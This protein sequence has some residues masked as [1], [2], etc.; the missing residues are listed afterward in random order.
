MPGSGKSK[1]EEVA[2][3][4]NFPIFNMG[5]VIREEV[6]K[7]GLKEGAKSYEFVMRDIRAKTGDQIVAK[8]TIQKL[9]QIEADI[10]CIDGVRSLE[11][12][13]YFRM[14]FEVKILAILSS[15]KIRLQR[16]SMRNRPDDPKT[17]KELEKR[18]RTELELG[19]G[20]VIATA[21]YFIIND[22]RPQDDFKE[23]IRAKLF[24]SL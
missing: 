10:V 19:L 6:M 7:R 15:F 20:K 23:R 18:D 3:E 24:E 2:K 13:R 17:S 1:V 12:V 5:D 21:D 16:L 9:D 4:L 8:R 14:F 11:E 22:S